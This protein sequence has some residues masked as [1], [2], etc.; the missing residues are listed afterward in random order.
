[1]TESLIVAATAFVEGVGGLV[2]GEGA[3]SSGACAD[4]TVVVAPSAAMAKN[5]H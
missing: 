2:V 3:D 1:M 4:A 5:T